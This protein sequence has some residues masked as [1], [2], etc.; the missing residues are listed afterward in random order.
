MFEPIERFIESQTV[1]QFTIAYGGPATL[2]LLSESCQVT[3]Q[4]ND[5]LEFIFVGEDFELLQ[6]SR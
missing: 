2:S 4:D 5:E 3:R 1:G 6:G